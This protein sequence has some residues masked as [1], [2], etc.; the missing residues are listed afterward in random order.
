MQLRKVASISSCN[1]HLSVSNNS[2]IYKWK[3]TSSLWQEWVKPNTR[4]KSIACYK[5]TKSTKRIL[6]Q[7]YK[8]A[9]RLND[10]F[11]FRI[12]YAFIVQNVLEE[13]SLCRMKQIKSIYEFY[14]CIITFTKYAFD[15]IMSSGVLCY[16]T[17]I[18]FVTMWMNAFKSNETFSKKKWNSCNDSEKL[19]MI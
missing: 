10:F 8:S 14:I 16:W 12:K 7:S 3:I 15:A 5:C 17:I 1:V 9:L 6:L 2:A 4:L 18:M 13:S 11:F 19:F